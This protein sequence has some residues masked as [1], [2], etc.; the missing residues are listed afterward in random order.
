MN[1]NA[2]NNDILKLFEIEVE[3]LFDK[4]L[5]DSEL[6]DYYNQLARREIFIN[7]IIDDLCVAWAKQIIDWNRQDKNVPVEDRKP[8]KIYINTDGGDV[9]AMNTLI[10]AIMLS[11]TPCYT[12]GMGR[13]FSAGS[14][15]L[16]AP[17][18]ENRYILSTT[19]VMIHK[20]SAGIGGDVN[21]IIDYSDF[22]KQDSE[23]SK[24]Y[25]LN[26]TTISE[27]KYT[28]VQDKDWYVFSEECLEYGIAGHI[29]SDI[30]EI[31]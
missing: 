4:H 6:L 8:I 11:K 23:I 18:V 29:I 26:R 15:I 31:P 9:T 27:E 22:L 5:P 14:Q 21:K 17:P 24:K 3:G 25:I 30:D 2:A 19:I 12:I 28:K 13:C 16:I 7:Y 10:S 1:H 20:G